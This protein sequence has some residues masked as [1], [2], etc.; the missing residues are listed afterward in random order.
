MKL[1]L[2]DTEIFVHPFS[3]LISGS[4]ASGKSFLLKEILKYKNILIKDPPERIIFCYSA[5]QTN[6]DE[7]QRL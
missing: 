5:W 4:T 3:C 2:I 1:W 6:Y 7:I